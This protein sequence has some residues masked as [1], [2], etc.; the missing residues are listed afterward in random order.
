MKLDCEVRPCTTADY[1]TPTVRPANSILEN[2]ALKK[3][4]LNL[5]QDWREDLRE[6]ASRYREALLREVKTPS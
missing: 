5:M 1:P 3:A 6:Y 4:N 2:A